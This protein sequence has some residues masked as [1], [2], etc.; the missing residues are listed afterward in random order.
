MILLVTVKECLARIVGYK[1]YLDGS[2]GVYQHHI[3]A[4]TGDLSAVLDPADLKRVPV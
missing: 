1:L 3:L 4:H 2:T